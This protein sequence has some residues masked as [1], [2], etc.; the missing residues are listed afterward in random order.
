MKTLFCICAL[1]FFSCSRV[2]SPDGVI[3]HEHDEN[4]DIFPVITVDKPTD[5]QQ[6]ANGDTIFIKGLFSDNKKLYNA[7]IKIHDDAFG[8][9]IKQQYFETHVSA[10]IPFDIYHITTV[11]QP[12]NYTISLEVEDHGFNK[13]Y[14]TMKIKVNP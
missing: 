12:S 8:S 11:T 6:F 3:N 4:D 5:N 7:W 10:T 14:K 2:G 13:S 1:F 9:L